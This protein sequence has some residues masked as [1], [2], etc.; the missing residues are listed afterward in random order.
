MTI[1]PSITQNKTEKNLLMQNDIDLSSVQRIKEKKTQKTILL[2]IK[3]VSIVSSDQLDA[4]PVNDRNQRVSVE[5]NVR[6]L[7]WRDDT[8]GGTFDQ[9][10]DQQMSFALTSR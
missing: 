3:R 6:I 4:R 1:D 10:Q 2:R 9:H 7:R 8:R 5:I